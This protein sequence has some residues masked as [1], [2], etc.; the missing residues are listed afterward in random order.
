MP[1]TDDH[2]LKPL[3]QWFC[4]TCD[5]IIQTHEQGWVEWFEAPDSSRNKFFGLVHRANYSPLKPFSD[6]Y[7]A[8]QWEKETNNSGVGDGSIGEVL[9]KFKI[10]E[11]E[12]I[13]SANA[14]Q[15]YMHLK[16]RLTLPY[17]EEA[18]RYVVSA[19]ND[20]LDE[21]FSGGLQE[22]TLYKGDSS[23]QNLKE[24]IQVGRELYGDIVGNPVLLGVRPHVDLNQSYRDIEASRRRGIP[25][26]IEEWRKYYISGGTFGLKS[27][28]PEQTAKEEGKDVGIL[29]NQTPWVSRVE[30]RYLF[31]LQLFQGR[32]GEAVVEA[33]FQACN[34]EV[35]HWGAEFRVGT[36]NQAYLRRPGM[37]KESLALRKEPDVWVMHKVKPE[38]FRIEIKSTVLPISAW[39]YQIEDLKS[40][41][42]YYSDVVLLVCHYPGLEL[43]AKKV[44]DLD[45]EAH[46]IPSSMVLFD[47]SKDFS[48]LEEICK[49]IDPTIL[50]NVVEKLK[51]KLSSLTTGYRI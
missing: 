35:G 30:E 12:G 49:G 1:E 23:G 37:N 6:C 4:D 42:R 2:S 26:S 28:A 11:A 32:I 41:Q 19:K 17:Y 47:L 39:S 18:Y 14:Y 8:I 20:G 16:R 22:N 25:T 21:L 24:V 48:P 27:E 38:A 46:R 50:Q 5:G 15:V 36:R 40:V 9:G 3:E 10:W 13:P 45:L 33:I 44:E 34:Y 51:K 43:F 29:P 7:F 31:D